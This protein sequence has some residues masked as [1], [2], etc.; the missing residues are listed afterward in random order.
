[1]T[2]LDVSCSFF[3]E[4][5]SGRLGT[6]V[7]RVAGWDFFFL[8][9]FLERLGIEVAGGLTGG[10]ILLCT[11]FTGDRGGLRNPY[12]PRDIQ[13]KTSRSN[14][15]RISRYNLENRV[16][17]LISGRRGEGGASRFSKF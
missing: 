9:F 10:M 13:W 4:I 16:L 3:G 15:E 7:V 11:I 14:L 12:C 2:G 17:N 1:M 8:R 6:G 5:F